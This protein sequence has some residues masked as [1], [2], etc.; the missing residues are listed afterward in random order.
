MN[1]CLW[2]K[3]PEMGRKK[4]VV[5]H[6][7]DKQI[8]FLPG[9]FF[10]HSESLSQRANGGKCLYS[11]FVVPLSAKEIV[12]HSNRMPPRRQVQC[13]WPTTV[14]ISTQNADVHLILHKSHLKHLCCDSF[15][16]RTP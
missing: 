7:T 2:L 10:P 4:F 3:G 1:D 13:R 16:A 6:V 8:N 5:R 11:E 9:E 15:S 14:A 12:N